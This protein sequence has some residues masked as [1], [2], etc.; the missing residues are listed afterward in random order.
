MTDS[1]VSVAKLSRDYRIKDNENSAGISGFFHPKYKIIHALNKISFDIKQGDILGYIGENGAGKSTTIKILLGILKPTDGNVTVF[2]KNPFLN[3]KQAALHVG[4][5]MGQKSQLWWEL[6]LID[7][8][9]F[10]QKLYKRDSPEDDVWL[11]KMI[12]RLDVLEFLQQPVRELS[13]GQRMR[14]EFI[15]TFIHQPDLVFLD[16]P[17]LG[18]D[19]LTRK[20][21]LDFL[22]KINQEKKTTIIFTSHDIEDIEKIANKLLILR[23]GEIVY[24]GNVNNFMGKYN[25]YRLIQV[26]GINLPKDQLQSGVRLFRE[27]KESLEYLINTKEMTQSAFVDVL[28]KQAEVESIKN[29]SVDLETILSIRGERNVNG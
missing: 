9:H 4:A 25:Y 2:G 22:V 7:S 29:I 28:T 27:N 8:F 19:T 20:R 12:T 24:R 15:A 16:E 13:L 3:R 10:L 23:H 1:V 14:G 6:P 21:V 5:L 26:T 11:N 18:L 17:T